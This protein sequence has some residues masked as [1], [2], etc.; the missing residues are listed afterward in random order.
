M[1]L[2]HGRVVESLRFGWGLLRHTGAL[3][4]E[5][6]A[7]AITAMVSTPKGTHLTLVEVQPEAPVTP[8][9]THA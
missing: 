3:L 5:N 6:V 2:A 1:V 4:P 8:D 9:R 7:A